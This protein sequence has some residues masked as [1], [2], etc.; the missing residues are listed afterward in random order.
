MTKKVLRKTVHSQ[1]CA[2]FFRRSVVLSLPAV[3][4]RKVSYFEIQLRS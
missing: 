2:T 1:S 3:L 4:L